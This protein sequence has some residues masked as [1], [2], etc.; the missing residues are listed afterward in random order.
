MAFIT[1]NQVSLHTKNDQFEKDFSVQYEI[2]PQE[3]GSVA[4]KIGRKT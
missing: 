3:I 1:I 4:D 2:T